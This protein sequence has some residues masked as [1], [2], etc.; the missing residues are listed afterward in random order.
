MTPAQQLIMDELE[1]GVIC[2][3]DYITGTGPINFYFEKTGSPIR[4]DVVLRMIE[5]NLLITEQDGFSGIAYR[6]G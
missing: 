3:T 4:R 1:D 2:Y 6:R 5:A